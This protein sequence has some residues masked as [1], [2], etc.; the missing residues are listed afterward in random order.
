VLLPQMPIRLITENGMPVL[1]ICPP[2]DIGPLMCILHDSHND[3]AISSK[4]DQGPRKIR[5]TVESPEL[6]GRRT[7]SR[8]NGSFV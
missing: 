1:L 5:E 8:Q 3:R 6:D 4:E 2:S 7:C